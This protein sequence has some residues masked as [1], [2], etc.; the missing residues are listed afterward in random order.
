MLVI[1]NKQM[2]E[3]STALE[4]RYVRECCS[5][6]RADYP[7]FASSH[8]TDEAAALF[9]RNGIKKAKRYL[10]IGR[11]DVKVFL[12]FQAAFGDAFDEP[13]GLES[14]RKILLTRNLNGT[15]KIARM[16]GKMKPENQS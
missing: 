8:P 1:T 6:L 2:A 7:S 14:L 4:Q 15:E 5:M 11:E 3:I 10:I 16:L 12:R 9:V 13:G